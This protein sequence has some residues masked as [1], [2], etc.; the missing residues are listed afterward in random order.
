[1]AGVVLLWI[2]RVQRERQAA[3]SVIKSTEE[4]LLGRVNSCDFL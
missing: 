2:R 1:M 4:R 3:L